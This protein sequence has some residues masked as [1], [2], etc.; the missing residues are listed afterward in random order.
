MLALPLPLLCARAWGQGTEGVGESSSGDGTPWSP[1]LFVCFLAVDYLWSFLV[2]G[3]PAIAWTTLRIRE[4][5]REISWFTLW[6]QPAALAGS[7]LANLLL[8]LLD[9]AYAQ[10]R[11]DEFVLAHYALHFVLGGAAIGLVIWHFERRRWGLS[12]GFAWTMSLVGA[13][14]MNPASG[15]YALA[16][17][18]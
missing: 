7:L 10:R 16:A 2:I 9:P 18:S 12:R 3:W 5:A 13:V 4:M 14:L 15:G 1:F 6:I 8:R 17:W 11:A